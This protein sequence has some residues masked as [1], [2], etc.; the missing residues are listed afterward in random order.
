MIIASSGV[1]IRE[2]V[3]VWQRTGARQRTSGLVGLGGFLFHET[4]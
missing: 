4:D 1:I 3:I 2:H